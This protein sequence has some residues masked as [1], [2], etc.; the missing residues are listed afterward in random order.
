M[1]ITNLTIRIFKH[2][3]QNAMSQSLLGT[4][5]CSL[6][7]LVVDI[8]VILKVYHLNFSA[9]FLLFLTFPLIFMNILIRLFV[10]LSFL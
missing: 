10:Y 6:R 7:Y 5:F 3:G 4:K 2:F 1:D 8:Q 9:N